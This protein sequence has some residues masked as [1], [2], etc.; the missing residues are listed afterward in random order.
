[1]ALSGREASERA[2]RP[3]SLSGKNLAN[4]GHSRYK[5]ES[6]AEPAY[7][8][9]APQAIFPE[10]ASAL[11]SDFARIFSGAFTILY[12]PKMTFFSRTHV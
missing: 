1:V 10:G 5:C 7:W 3:S 9:P 12:P 2:E 6:F 8:R 4:N 11:E